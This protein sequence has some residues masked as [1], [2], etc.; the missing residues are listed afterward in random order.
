MKK[1]TISLLLTLLVTSFLALHAGTVLANADE[2]GTVTI[3]TALISGTN[4]VVTASAPVLPPS[5]DGKFYLFAEKVYSETL[6]GTP[7]ASA[8]LSAAVSFAFPLNYGTA[9]NHLYDK[10]RVA[11]LQGGRYVPVT[12][13]RYIT[14]PEALAAGSPARKNAGKK[15]LILDSVKVGT[16]EVAALGVKQGAYNIN[17]QDVIGGN[18]L[19][20]YNYNGKTYFFDSYS[21]GQYDY[22][23]RTNTAQGI[24]MTIV[25][26]NQRAPGEEFMLSPVSRGGRS[27]YYMMNTSDDTGLEYL[28]AVVSFLAER[29]N[30]K[31]GCGQVDNWVIGNEVNARAIWNYTAPMDVSS[32]SLLYAN[33]LRVCY[34]AIRSKNASA[35]VCMSL[36]QNWT[37]SS[38][39]STYTARSVLEAVNACI[40]VEGNFDWALAEHPYNYPMTWTPFWAPK[41]EASRAMVR[42]DMDT[43]YLSME[44]IEQLT[45]YMCLPH[46][47]NTAG[48]VRPILLTEVGYT[49]TQGE[50]Q[51][52]AAIVYAYQRAATNR[53]I[54][55][56]IF[57]RQTD[58]PVEVSAGLSVGLS[59]MNGHQKVAF[60]TFSQMD[61][62]GAAACIQKAQ[63][64]MGIADWNAAMF[65]R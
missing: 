6:T 23:I 28:E 4:V 3:N 17:L 5:D 13:Y 10:F 32:Y 29:Y 12:A 46:M 25:L 41:S 62:N 44:N 14:N 18:G 2:V 48:G 45:D 54:N 65:P 64:V 11:V 61:G 33:E 19:V 34:N 59:S 52:A 47:R 58:Y 30:G 36:D 53:Y 37:A 51:Q 35:Y 22:C 1:I 27:S 8:P 57:N 31:N 60:S 38:N 42:H 21:L 20:K 49:S 24:A 63:S 56:I 55:M 16:P 50:E 7:V 40:T 9:T 39:G 26:L 43:P 15:G